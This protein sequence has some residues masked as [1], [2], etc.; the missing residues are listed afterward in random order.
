[1]GWG[2]AKPPSVEQHSFQLIPS[3]AACCR[4]GAGRCL[5]ALGMENWRR[6]VGPAP[7]CTLQALA[8][9]RAAWGCRN[10]WMVLSLGFIPAVL[11]G[12]FFPLKIHCSNSKPYSECGHVSVMLLLNLMRTEEFCSHYM[13]MYLHKH[14]MRVNRVTRNTLPCSFRVFTQDH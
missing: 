1:M 6:A 3:S 4:V 10:L 9:L 12:F 14:V 13:F 8:W 5:Q 2:Q 7:S 11:T